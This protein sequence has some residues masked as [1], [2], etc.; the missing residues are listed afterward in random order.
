MLESL[1]TKIEIVELSDD[2]N[3]GK[4]TM[5]PMESGY[6]TTLGNSLRRVLLSSIPGAAISKIK[7]D[8]GVQHEFST[9]KGVMEDVTEIILNIKGIYI[10]KL[11]ESEDPINLRL[12]IVGPKIVTAGDI[13]E[14][15]DVEIIN[16]DHYICTINEEGELHMDLQVIGGRGY[17]ISDQN[18]SDDDPIGTIA[19]D[20]SF[21]PVLKV[22]FQVEDTRVEQ[23]IDYD[24]LTLEVWTNGT[25]NA[26]EATAKGAKIIISYLELF[27]DLPSYVLEEEV[28]EEPEE[29]EEVVTYDKMIEDLDLSLRSF[30]CLKKED[31]NTVGD[32][33]DRGA[34]E[35]KKIRNFGKKSY[36]E[37]E[38]A[39]KKLGLEIPDGK[40]ED[41]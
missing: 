4:F 33:L 5:T 9:V 10:K 24:K 32:I 15:Q 16:K 35:L 20:S 1:N 7:F 29:E 21:T 23:I 25:I 6:G 18:K 3:Y 37:V 41:E 8:E 26:Q 17:N 38:E 2:G 14:N 39:I 31:I 30:H 11:T 12:D 36:L 28:E 19:I 13:E 40:K 22:N 34:N 27:N